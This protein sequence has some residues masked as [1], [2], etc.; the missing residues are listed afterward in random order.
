MKC[1]SIRVIS[2]GMLAIAAPVWAAAPVDESR[3]H[4]VSTAKAAHSFAP[5][6][7]SAARV[8]EEVVVLGRR[9]SPVIVDRQ[10]LKAEMAQTI[11]VLNERFKVS[12]ETELKQLKAPRLELASGEDLSAGRLPPA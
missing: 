8:M 4:D 9:P 1:N 6:L 10:R 11:R 12:I 3:V 7:D 2:S 5:E